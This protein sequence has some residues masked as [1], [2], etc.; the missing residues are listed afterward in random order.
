MPGSVTCARENAR[1]GRKPS[2]SAAGLLSLD[3]PE[4]RSPRSLD[5]PRV[6]WS[7]GCRIGVEIGFEPRDE[8]GQHNVR[9]VPFDNACWL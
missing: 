1:L 3:W 9:L 4:N 2:P 8:D 5:W 7:D 6:R